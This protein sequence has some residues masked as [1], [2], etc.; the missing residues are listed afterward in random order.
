MAIFICFVHS[1]SPASRTSRT[2]SMGNSI[3][4]MEPVTEQQLNHFLPL[5]FSPF[6]LF[7]PSSPCQEHFLANT[8][9]WNTG[10]WLLHVV[11]A[12]SQHN[13][14]GPKASILREREPDRGH[15]AF[16]DLASEVKPYHFHCLL[17][18]EAVTKIFPSSKTGNIPSQRRKVNIT[19][20][21]EHV[22]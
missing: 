8:M 16:C 19:S 17:F 13:G 18:A 14:W 11:R 9:D 5:I 12:S 10:K 15:I 7:F 3:I 2:A 22:G 20:Q 21:K 6:H 1:C 4:F